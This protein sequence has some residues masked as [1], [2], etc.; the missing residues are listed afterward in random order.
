MERFSFYFN[1][2]LNNNLYQ[3]LKAGPFGITP[4]NINAQ[5]ALFGFRILFFYWFECSNY[6]FAV[7]LFENLIKKGYSYMTFLVQGLFAN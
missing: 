7:T 2:D 4:P 1:L 6:I 5:G 3:V